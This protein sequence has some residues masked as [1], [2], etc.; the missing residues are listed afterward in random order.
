M[1]KAA[2]ELEEALTIDVPQF[3]TPRN[4][5]IV[6]IKKTEKSPHF[7]AVKFKFDEIFEEFRPSY[8]LHFFLNPVTF[9]N[10]IKRTIAKKDEPQ[11]SIDGP[12]DVQAEIQ[13]IHDAYRNDSD[14][15][16]V[17]TFPQ[18]RL[19]EYKAD[20]MNDTD[21]ITLLLSDAFV[22]FVINYGRSG[23]IARMCIVMNDPGSNGYLLAE[24][25]DE[26][27]TGYTHAEI[28][29]IEKFR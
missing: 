4:F 14:R 27:G 28:N 23:D 15:I 18:V 26:I 12:M 21:T 13:R 24:A 20:T 9:E 8:N 16:G 5:K 17:H 11:T 19:T 3:G 2:K 25:T 10:A 22:E 29:R 7:W 1:S 6:E